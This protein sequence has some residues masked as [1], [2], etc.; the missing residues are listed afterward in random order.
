M[1]SAAAMRLELPGGHTALVGM[2][3]SSPDRLG[4]HELATLRLL[5]RQLS[6]ISQRRL[7][8]RRD[9]ALARAAPP[10][11]APAGRPRRGCAAR[12]RADTPLSRAC[13]SGSTR[14]CGW[15]PTD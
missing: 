9:A 7:G 1:E 14:W 5:A 2:F 12:A 4:H 10:G 6:A 15:S 11:R 13:P 8:A 3:D